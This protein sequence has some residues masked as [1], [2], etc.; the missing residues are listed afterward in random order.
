MSEDLDIKLY[1]NFAEGDNMCFEKLYSKY[2]SSVQYFIVNIVKDYQRAEDIY[3]DVFM[4][5]FKNKPKIETSFKNYIYIASRNKAI[6]HIQTEKRREYI[7]NKYLLDLFQDEKIDVSKN[8]EE[9]ESKKEVLKVIDKLEDKYKNAVYLTKIEGF[10]YSEVANILGT[11]ESNIKNLVHRGKI[12]MKKIII[13]ER[14]YNMEK[15]LRFII[16]FIIIALVLTTGV[17]GVA[18]IFKQKG[19]NSSLIPTPSIKI[20]NEDGNKVWCGTF[21]FVWNDLMDELIKGEIQFEDDIPCEL[22]DELNAKPFTISDLSEDSYVKIYGA[23][24]N[25]LKNKIENEI[26]EKFGENSEVL[27][28]IDWTDQ[29]N[30]VLYAM[31]KKEFH[32]IQEFNLIGKK[33]FKNSSTKYE[34]F[35]INLTSLGYGSKNVDVLFYNSDTDFAVK[36]KSREGEE[37]YLYRNDG[38][39]K[40]FIENYQEMLKKAQNYN[41][42][43]VIESGDILE[44]PF[45]RIKENINYDEL[46]NRKIKGNGNVIKKA[47][48]TVDFELNNI[49][50]SLKSEAVINVYK[51]IVKPKRH[52]IFND[53]FLVFLKEETKERPY[54]ALRVYD[55]DILVENREK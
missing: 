20:T 25:E 30:Y 41:G 2:K 11:S 31:L 16:I 49:G 15:S 52:F 33:P 47:I 45:I 44:V 9:K 37:V 10:S 17:W 51:S 55:T 32:F 19:K 7:D 26:M 39:G 40:S 48:Q 1:N 22:A 5:I 3:Q 13:N 43:K 28:S 35:G 36:L 23:C 18:K 6:S 21:N 50:G 46:C 12:K 34:Y 53:T 42:N 24:S 14:W 27:D 54:F 29:Q 8:L 38:N 4:C